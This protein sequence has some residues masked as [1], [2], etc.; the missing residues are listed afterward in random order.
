[1][2]ILTKKEKDTLEF[3]ENYYKDYNEYPL[4]KEIAKGIG[5]KSKGVVHRYIKSLQKLGKIQKTSRKHRGLHLKGDKKL[6]LR[7]LGKIAAGGPIEAISDQQ[8]IELEYLFTNKK[9]YALKVKG[10]SMIEAGIFDGDW[11]IVEESSRIHPSKAHVILIDNQDVTL[12]FVKKNS[13]KEVKLIPANK[14]Y[15][16]KIYSVDRVTIQGHVVGQVRIY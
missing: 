9:S 11:V 5:I 6:F 8:K 16:E 12:K 7:S 10:D 14:K 4:L 15:T 1:M 13:S 3:I 2:T